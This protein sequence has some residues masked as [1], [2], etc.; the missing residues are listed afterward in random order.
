MS[1]I[2]KTLIFSSVMISCSIV[3]LGIAFFTRPEYE[4][5]TANDRANRP[6]FTVK[7]NKRDGTRCLMREGWVLFVDNWERAASDFSVPTNFCKD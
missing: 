6:A 7:I 4:F 3:G 1:S 2:E 5:I